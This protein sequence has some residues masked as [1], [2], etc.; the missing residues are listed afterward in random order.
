MSK[1]RQLSKT[2]KLL[3]ELN[4]DPGMRE[5]FEA[6][7]MEALGE[8]VANELPSTPVYQIVVGA[9]GLGLLI[10]LVAVA[11]ITI[12]GGSDTEV[13]AIFVTVASTIVGAMAGLLAPQP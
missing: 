6:N 11:W 5:K 3:A 8:V 9:L 4:S 7:P 12:Q 1:L 13:P 2:K 10:S